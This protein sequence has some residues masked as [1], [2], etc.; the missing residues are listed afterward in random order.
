MKRIMMWGLAALVVLFPAVLA[1]PASV[2]TGGSPGPGLLGFSREDVI[3]APDVDFAR[4][5]DLDGDG[6]L[7]I[8][9]VESGN[10]NID[11]WE[12]TFG[13]GTDFARHSIT[14]LSHK[15]TVVSPGDIDGDGDTDF[16]ALSPEGGKVGLWM[17]DGSGNFTHQSYSDVR[18]L[19]ITYVEAADVNNDGYA[20]FFGIDDPRTRDIFWWEN[21]GQPAAIRF[22]R[23]EVTRN[24]SGNGAVSRLDAV[25]VDRDGLV[26]FVGANRGAGR[27]TWWRHSVDAGGNHVFQ[28]ATTLPNG[29]SEPAIKGVVAADVDGDS[30]IDILALRGGTDANFKYRV[31]LWENQGGE[32]FNRLNESQGDN[33]GNLMW[34]SIDSG[35]INGDGAVDFVLAERDGRLCWYG[36]PHI[37]SEPS[38]TATTAPTGTSTPVLTPTGTV[39]PTATPT[40]TTTPAAGQTQKNYL[41]LIRRSP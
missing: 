11:W 4:V 40:V 39:T 12:N 25:D 17:N 13:D 33:P 14:T 24:S 31:F 21:N 37:P 5:A 2:A 16:F 19:G 10:E 22:Q 32:T 28:N 7:D 1:W 20:D 23:H 30:D 36:N 29:Y 18:V 8:L 9:A 15:V 3:R 38:P 35:D 26:D 41:P 27:I 34:P 6:D